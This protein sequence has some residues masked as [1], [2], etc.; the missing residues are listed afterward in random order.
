MTDPTEVT[1]RYALERPPT[2]E[3]IEEAK[4]RGLGRRIGL[5]LRRTA[6]AFAAAEDSEPED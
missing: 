2:A 6:R 3:E 4:A 5:A 1:Q